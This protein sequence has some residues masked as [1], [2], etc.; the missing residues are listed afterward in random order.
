MAL[1]Q[2]IVRGR[3]GVLWTVLPG[4]IRPN[5]DN[6]VT[7]RSPRGDAIV[8]D[9]AIAVQHGNADE[10][11]LDTAVTAGATSL[12]VTGVAEDLAIV[13]P[14]SP[15]FWLGGR[16]YPTG[17]AT[18]E[19]HP[20]ELVRVQNVADGGSGTAILTLWSPLLYA[21]ETDA[22]LFDALQLV[23]VPASGAAALWYG[24]H[25]DWT[26][27]LHDRDDADPDEVRLGRVITGV[28]CVR[29]PHVRLAS[30]GDMVA[31]CPTI[32][33]LLEAGRDVEQMLDVAYERVLQRLGA[34]FRVQTMI[35][36]DAMIQA[37]I[38]QT[39]VSLLAE[40]GQQMVPLRNYYAAELESELSQIMAT[41]AFDTDQDGVAETHGRGFH[42]IR[43]D[44]A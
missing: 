13:P 3:G 15:L 5:A 17:P 9:A 35:G 31:V 33:S 22:P 4:G 28:E 20:R 2:H 41:R 36:D 19:T 29:L 12:I 32:V 21:H 43:V 24:G 11:A 34:R 37:T 30:W 26:Y 8:T 23:I 6:L 40:G 14:Y 39:L 42:S 10:W 38:Y 44:R 16:A 7:V 1:P 27:Q 18:D 25:A